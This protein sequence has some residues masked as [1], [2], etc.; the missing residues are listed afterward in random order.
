MNH[1]Q[2]IIYL[3]A[4]FIFTG[5]FL[6]SCSDDSNDVQGQN[7]E[8]TPLVEAI[9]V[10]TGNLP[11]IHRSTGELRA[12]N[13]IEIYP[14]VNAR[15]TQVL[16][17]NG[18]RV[19]EGDVLIRLRDDEIRE[20]LNQAEFD[21]EISQAQVRQ[22][23]A[24]LRRLEAQ[25]R[26]TQEL[27]ERELESQLQLETIQA[28]ID[29]AEANVD[30]ARS[31]MNRTASQVEERRTQLENTV[32]RAPISGVV[33]S[34]NA[35]VGQQVDS[36]SQLFQIGDVDNMRIF[37]NLTERMSNSIH[38]GDRAEVMTSTSSG[39]TI[40]AEVRRIS[41]FLDPITHSTVAE[42]EVTYNS[43]VLMPGMFVT[44]DIFYGQAEESVLVPKTALY[45][46]PMEGQMGVYLADM[47]SLELEL[48][49]DSDEEN[50][51][52]PNP[53]DVTFVPV[54]VIAEGRGV[55]GID[56]VSENSWVVTVGQN[57]IA[58]W[59]SERAH[60]RTVGWDR[61]M[62]LQNLQSRDMERL[63]FG[64]NY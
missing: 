41:P 13:Q 14:E 9:R 58:E 56:G 26:R 15:I 63:I 35:E 5:L 51:V 55:A 20:Q 43:G 59:E 8:Q 60:V 31:Q 12:R 64:N 28:Q 32:V 36:G 16:V 10:Q 42:L 50:V 38:S 3:S 11:L 17:E 53:V 52:T 7:F 18:D 24:N 46:H 2:K 4:L 39:N 62:E 40:E 19:E 29:E 54:N 30:L 21:Y 27:A 47:E 23:E 1:T 45:D 6:I 25:F 22:A 57:Q 49:L 34:K 44:V 37:V 33:G 48:G 61:V